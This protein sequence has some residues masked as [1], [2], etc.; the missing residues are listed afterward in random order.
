M[1]DY[2]CMALNQSGDSGLG[3]TKVYNQYFRLD[4]QILLLIQTFCCPQD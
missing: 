3:A 1:R 4:S 2:G